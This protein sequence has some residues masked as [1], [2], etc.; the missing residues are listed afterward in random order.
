MSL[1]FKELPGWSFDIDEVSAGVY[2]ASGKDRSGRSVEAIGL[3]PDELL[4]ECKR[5]AAKIL[6]GSSEANH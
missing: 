2:K 6:F 5:A 3:D 1:E 4:K